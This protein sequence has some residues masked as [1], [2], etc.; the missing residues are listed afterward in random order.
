MNEDILL[1][2]LRRLKNMFNVRRLSGVRIIIFFFGHYVRMESV[3][4]KWDNVPPCIY[5]DP[6]P[7]FF[8]SFFKSPKRW[9]NKIALSVEPRCM[10]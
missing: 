3:H 2:V 9:V 5:P 1:P 8:V 6:L 7:S 4:T 10:K